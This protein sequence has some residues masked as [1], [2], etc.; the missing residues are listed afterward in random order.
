MQGNTVGMKR[1]GTRNVI[2]IIRK[3]Y[4]ITTIP[5]SPNVR[6][7]PKDKEGLESVLYYN[8]RE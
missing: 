1:I 5:N 3:R 6:T 4:K 8:G 7:K 2:L